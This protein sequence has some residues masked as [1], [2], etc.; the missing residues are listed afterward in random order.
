MNYLNEDKMEK[1]HINEN[2]WLGNKEQ[3]IITLIKFI[4]NFRR[5]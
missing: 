5:T 2:T 4:L 3:N 1:N